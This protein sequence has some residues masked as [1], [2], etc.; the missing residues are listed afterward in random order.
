MLLADEVRPPCW[1]QGTLFYGT[2]DD[3]RTEQD[4]DVREAEAK[5]LCHGCPFRMRC[6]ERAL[7]NR[8]RYGV[9]GGMGEAERAR[10]RDHL[11]KEGYT[12]RDM[13]TGRELTAA[14]RSFYKAERR[15]FALNK[16]ALG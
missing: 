16:V 7:V 5:S 13:P 8:E 15:A 14:L 9:W 10:F 6:L 2:E 4:R 12:N 3:G 1:D 11:I